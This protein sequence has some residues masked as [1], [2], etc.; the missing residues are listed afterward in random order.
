MG[1]TS[2]LI[3][4]TSSIRQGTLHTLLSV[5]LLFLCLAGLILRFTW[6]NW[7]QGANLH[8]DE[9]GLTN[10]LTQLRIPETVG[11]YFNTRLS[12]L[13]PYSRYDENGVLIAN[14]PDNGMR[15]GQ[16][17]M[18]IIR[19]TAEQTGN[20]GYDEL[21][22]AGRKL[23]AFAD[24]LSVLLIYMIGCRL[25][26]R[27]VGLLAAALSSWTVLQIQQSHFMTV[28]N[29]AVLFTML[30]MYTAIRIA[31]QQPMH[32]QIY[33]GADL[34]A[35]GEYMPVYSSLAWYLLFGVAFGMALASKIN[36]L[37]LGGM[38]L[39]AGFV[40]IAD[41]RLKTRQDLQRIFLTW[42]VFTAIAF[43]A[44]GITFR[45]TQP[46]SFRQMAGDTSVFDLQ[47]NPDWVENMKRAQAESG[48]VGGG[49]PGEQWAHRP[50]IIFPWINMVFWGMGIPL[51]LMSW[52]GF[53]TALWRLLRFGDR[54]RVHLLPLV[55]TGGYFFFMATRWVKSIRY[56]LPIYPFLALFAAWALVELWR[57]FVFARNEKTEGQSSQ[58]KARGVIFGL[59]SCAVVIGTI[60]WALAFVQAVYVTDHTRVQATEWIFQNIPGP[61]HLRF[62]DESGTGFAEPVAAPDG[63]V[64]RPG[65]DFLQS[66]T[67]RATGRLAEI[68]LPHV[69]AQNSPAALRVVILSSPN[70]ET[71]LDEVILPVNIHFGAGMES[72]AEFHGVE[73]N[74]G[75]VYYLR[76]SVT[77]NEPVT[78]NRTII[79]NESWDEGLPFP[80]DQRDP[81]GQVYRGVTMEVRWYDD[82][83]KRQ[84][85]LD[86]LSQADYIIL[87]SQRAIWTTCR[88]PKTY[89]MTMAYYQALFQGD[90]GFELAATFS[91]PLEIGPL[92]VSDVGGTIAIN[93]IPTL[94]LF[95]HSLLSAEEAFSVY[96][97]PPVWIFKKSPDFNLDAVSQFFYA[98]D[99]SKVVIQSPN[100]AS[101][102]PCILEEDIKDW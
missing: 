74:A 45:L 63:L 3:S 86:V 12:P 20:I 16:W 56:F 81:F 44:A 50:A 88:I 8:P 31:Q 40:S 32:K 4:K 21:R 14:G 26:S 28:D 2:P 57:W 92:Y 7:S 59:V 24:V 76:A 19:F 82:E 60:V 99:L 25:Y 70:D 102:P 53:I 71:P 1:R 61:F 100:D 79:S 65:E 18:T 69:T 54:W 51:G 84:M 43:L 36:L 11:E 35:A 101:E 49:P 98:L 15:W 52:A 94:P 29:F 66:F 27:F 23:S 85:F 80:F 90:L 67:M 58:A 77:G 72:R 48:G 96:D 89:P 62:V 6:V 17:P 34:L 87:P 75:T 47:L 68:T 93:S 22:L 13:S 30:A 39:V 37:P 9:Y 97:H 5:S 42:G 55:W 78:V 46:M 64:I 33:R 10:T 41:L 38:V 95:N 73:L 83:N 91:A